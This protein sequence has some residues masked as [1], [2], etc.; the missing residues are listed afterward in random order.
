MK[1]KVLVMY[2]RYGS[3]HTKIAEYVAKYIEENNKNVEIMLLDMT[4]FGNRLGRIGVKVMDFVAKHRPEF[5]FDTCYEIMDHRL[6]VLGHNKFSKQ[7]YDN[8]KLRDVISAFNPDITISTHFYCSS[9]INYYNDLKL[10]NSK[11]LTIITDYRTHECWTRNYKKET[12]YI[13]GNEIVKEELIK[14]GVNPKKIYPFGLPLNLSQ[15]SNLDKE[16]DIYKR[17][18]IKGDRKVYLFFGGG[19]AGSMY[20]YDYFKTLGKLNLNADIIFISGKNTKLEN[21]C[22][23]FVKSRNIK[24]IKVL[25]Y[26]NDVFNL[27]KI[28]DLV[29]SKPGGATVTE[30]L[31]M[32]APMI[33]VPG[34]GGQE[35]YNARFVAKKKYGFKVRGLWKFKRILMQLE[36]NP[37][38]IDKMHSRM[39]KLDN[40]ESVK[41]INNLINKI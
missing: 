37:S 40:N 15:L 26:T 25:G 32:K 12:G 24:N 9:I 36:T 19:S 34:V 10:I 33:L 30:C 11:L 18:G 20:Y 41:K 5:I 8:Q 21:K 31:E 17:Y 2:A 13:V 38:I 28:S 14:R 6:S 3:G 1:K 35:K 23:K 29:I 4:E 7:S 39:L 27:L 16:N 22:K